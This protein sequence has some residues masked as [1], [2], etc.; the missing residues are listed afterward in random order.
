MSRAEEVRRQAREDMRQAIVDAARER[1]ATEGPSQLSL[2]AVARDVG[3]VS[4][5]VY[6]Y[7][8]SR[9]DLLTALIVEAYDAFGAAAEESEDAVAVDD[10]RGRWRA[11][12][13]GA[14]T[15]AHDH[16]HEWALLFGS[17]V[18]GYAAPQTTVDPATRVPRRMVRLLHDA[19]A[20]GVRLPD[21]EV[22]PAVRAAIGPVQEFFGD[23]LPAETVVRGLM[24]WTHLTGAISHELFGHRRNGADPLE[25]LFAAEVARLGDSVGLP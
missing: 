3:M 20:A 2:R 22:D 15:W 5:A 25:V 10:L 9:D 23:D 13:W 17:P 16:P 11:L 8:A 4:S 6:R 1:L 21:G 12:C 7:V 24:A 18:P 14:R 19:V